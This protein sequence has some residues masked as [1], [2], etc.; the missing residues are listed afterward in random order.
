M[1]SCWGVGE[2]LGSWCR[3]VVV[4]CCRA[5]V[6]SWCRGVV[7][8]ERRDKNTEL[9]CAA[10]CTAINDSYGLTVRHGRGSGT[11][12]GDLGTLVVTLPRDKRQWRSGRNTQHT[13]VARIRVFLCTHN[14]LKDTLFRSQIDWNILSAVICFSTKLTMRSTVSFALRARSVIQ[15]VAGQ[16]V[17]FRGSQRH[18]RIATLGNVFS[19]FT[20]LANQHKSE[21]LGQGF[22]SFGAPDFLTEKVEDLWSGDLYT[23]EVAEHTL[24]HQYTTPGC[25]PEL[26]EVSKHCEP[27]CHLTTSIF[28]L[29]FSWNLSLW[30]R[31]G[32]LIHVLTHR[33]H[34]CSL[35]NAASR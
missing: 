31:T 30:L 3:A 5:V 7:S 23:T 33:L 24:A 2:L 26:A 16:Q 22:P 15:K 14:E 27:S 1:G 4:S 21:N 34:R 32:T 28:A 11:W 35:Q 25:E 18:D 12:S 13:F 9:E 19:E 20:Q 8:F 17:R 10:C 29:S 6:L